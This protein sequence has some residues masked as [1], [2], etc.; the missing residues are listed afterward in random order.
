P[1]S[2][3]VVVGRLIGRSSAQAGY[4]ALAA[5]G[6]FSL[7]TTI[8][9]LRSLS[10]QVS[11]AG[12][13]RRRSSRRHPHSPDGCTRLHPSPC[14]PG[15]RRR[16]RGRAPHFLGADLLGAAAGGPLRDRPPRRAARGPG[17]RRPSPP[18]RRGGRGGGPPR[19]RRTQAAGGVTSRP[20]PGGGGPAGRSGSPPR[21][22]R[23][24]GAAR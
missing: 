11:A 24:P 13:R 3:E 20:P 10:P 4:L 2:F 23:G 17:G 1:V 22:R 5:V 16:L 6:C 15:R 19:R 18:R 12:P 9:L 7:L 21:R 8:A 14:H